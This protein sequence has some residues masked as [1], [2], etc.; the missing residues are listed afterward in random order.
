MYWGF[1][2]WHWL[3]IA[4]LSRKCLDTISVPAVYL[5]EKRYIQN[6]AHL[7]VQWIC[8]VDL[9]KVTKKIRAISVICQ[10]I[11]YNMNITKYKLWCLSENVKN[12]VVNKYR[13]LINAFNLLYFNPWLKFWGTDILKIP[14]VNHFFFLQTL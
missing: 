5:H 13:F 10:K 11:F 1:S 4:S 7:H 3:D 14:T 8:T 12:N 9:F 2:N 6:M